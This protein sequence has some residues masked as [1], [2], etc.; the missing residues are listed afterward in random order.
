MQGLQTLN[1]KPQTARKRRWAREG[2]LVC[3]DD[4]RSNT[5]A[6]ALGTVL[7]RG[8]GE[9]THRARALEEAAEAVM[10]GVGGVQSGGIVIQS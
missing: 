6:R 5:A 3:A 8:G 9:P 2:Q 7:A 10:Q 4:E 1:P